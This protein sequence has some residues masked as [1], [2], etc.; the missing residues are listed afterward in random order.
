MTPSDLVILRRLAELRQPATMPL[1]DQDAYVDLYKRGL[2]DWCGS[3]ISISDKG[4][5]ALAVA[6]VVRVV[7]QRC[8]RPTR[9]RADGALYKHRL[10]PTRSGIRTGHVCPGS[11][12]PSEAAGR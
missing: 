9:V 5:A 12:A 3:E 7:C 2:V 6:A 8:G 11:G 10:H 1:A 4:R